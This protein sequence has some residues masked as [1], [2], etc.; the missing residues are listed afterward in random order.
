MNSYFLPDE[1]ENQLMITIQK[2]CRSEFALIRMTKT[3]LDKSIMDASDSIRN[4]LKKYDIINYLNI[5]Q[6]EKVLEQANIISDKGIKERKVSYYRPKTKK[7]DPRFWVYNLTSFINVGELVYLT[8]HDSKLIVIPL[9][10]YDNF[11]KD[12]SSY[13]GVDAAQEVITELFGLMSEV[14]KRGWIK[15]VSP[16][17]RYPKDVGDTLEEALGIKVNNLVSA[18]FKGY[19]EVKGKRAKAKTKDTL[20]SMVPNWDISHLKSSTDIMLQYGYHSKRHDDFIDLYVTVNNNPNNQGLYIEVDEENEQVHQKSF[21]NGV[22]ADVCSWRFEDIKSRLEE[23]HPN[24]LWVLAEESV[25]DGMIHFKYTKIQFS[26]R[27]IFSQFLSLLQQGI[28]T[29]DWRGRVKP[30]RTKYKDKGHCFRL[31][32]SQRKLLFGEVTDVEL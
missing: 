10:H 32:P 13:F 25:I 3:M 2:Y 26:R 5:D 17:K 31:V 29:Y 4:L 7:G 18:D 23:K 9:I 15:S 20:F 28:V 22:E 19:V 27:P 24:T 1:S 6:G 12:I 14:K 21:L 8:V 16:Y 30:D 11:E